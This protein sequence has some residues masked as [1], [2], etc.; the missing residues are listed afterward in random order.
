M[1]PRPKNPPARARRVRTS[2]AAALAAVALAAAACEG[3]A[4]GP[5]PREGAPDA[6]R[7]SIGG[8]AVDV[9]EIELRGDTVVYRRTS[10]GGPGETVDSVRVVPTADAWRAFWEAADDAGVRRWR[11]RYLAEDVVDG[12]GWTLSLVAD[13]LQLHSAGSNAYPDHRGREHELEP[14]PAFEGFVAGA[15]ALIGRGF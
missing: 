10:W 15:G 5:L 14:T 7:F 9:R 3:D 6:L 4:M 8:F 13:G 1:T 12:S 11:T 2:V